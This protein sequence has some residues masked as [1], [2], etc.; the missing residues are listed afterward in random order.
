MSSA[1]PCASGDPS[2][3]NFLLTS[4]YEPLQLGIPMASGTYSSVLIAS[5][6]DTGYFIAPDYSVFQWTA[7]DSSGIVGRAAV[8]AVDRGKGVDGHTSRAYRA[9]KDTDVVVGS[10]V[11]L[12]SRLPLH[13]IVFREHWQG[14]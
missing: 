1:S 2:Q 13:V 8:L 6:R 12:E 10:E 7:I 3:H 11:C 5:Q 4:S 14:A 9:H